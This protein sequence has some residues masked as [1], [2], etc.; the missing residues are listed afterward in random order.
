MQSA[1][2][3][4]ADL[5]EHGRTSRQIDT[6]LAGIKLAVKP[7]DL[8]T[9]RQFADARIRKATSVPAFR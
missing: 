9:R 1:V 6:C 4:L 3:R 7:S 8:I 2:F 5:P